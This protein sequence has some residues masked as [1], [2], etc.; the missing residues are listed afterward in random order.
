MEKQSSHYYYDETGSMH[1]S[2]LSRVSVTMSSTPTVQPYLI[3]CCFLFA[4][5]MLLCVCCAML[6]CVKNRLLSGDFAANLY[7]LLHYPEV[8]IEHLLQ[9]ARDVVPDTSM[10]RVS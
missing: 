5:D 9:V 1:L 2:I 3:K 4:Q 7:L 10:H 6:I 8:D